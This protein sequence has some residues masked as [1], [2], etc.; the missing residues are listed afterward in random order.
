MEL[1][2]EKW[3]LLLLLEF[4]FVKSRKTH[5]MQLLKDELS[6][7]ECGCMMGI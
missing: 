7:W 6:R 4:A 1:E 5:S 2:Y 3:L